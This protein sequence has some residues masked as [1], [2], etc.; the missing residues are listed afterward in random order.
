MFISFVKRVSF[1][2]ATPASQ[3]ATH[4]RTSYHDNTATSKN[5]G[6]SSLYLFRAGG[7]VTT[8]ASPNVRISAWP[9]VII[10]AWPVAARQ[11]D[12]KSP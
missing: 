2:N 1:S 12:N 11:L 6:T 4:R 8:T 3:H 7:H 9:W 5:K 10:S